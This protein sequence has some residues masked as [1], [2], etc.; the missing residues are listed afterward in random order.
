MVEHKKRLE[1][2]GVFAGGKHMGKTYTANKLREHLEKQGK[3]VV[4]M[5]FAGALRTVCM[6]ILKAF[7]VDE[8]TAKVLLSE[9]KDDRD[10]GLSLADGV[11]IPARTSPRDGLLV[12]VGQAVREHVDRDAWINCLIRKIIWLGE[13]VDYVIVDDVRKPDEANALVRVGA[14]LVLAYRYG[15]QPDRSHE[16]Y[17]HAC[18]IAS[19]HPCGSCEEMLSILDEEHYGS[20]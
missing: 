16:D 20:R 1:V 19:N 7:G 9:G 13:E 3:R 8:Q 5:S 18:E 6:E 4:V 12:P 10:L 14:R 2:I 15:F 17:S 11:R